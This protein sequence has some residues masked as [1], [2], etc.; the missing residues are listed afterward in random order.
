MKN[1]LILVFSIISMLIYTKNSK[2]GT[3]LEPYAGMALSSTYTI[4]GGGS[5]EISGTVVGGRL[6]FQQLGFMAGLD[7]RRQSYEFKP[8]SGSDS[9]VTF[10]QLGF[11]VGYDFPILL[12]V[13]GQY[14]F[15]Y[16]GED[17]DDADIKYTGGSGTVL[18]VGYKIFPFISVNLEYSNTSTSTYESSAGEVDRDI[19][20][21]SYLLSVSLPLSL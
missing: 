4:D 18:G 9:E 10:T 5:G 21:Q 12:R 2:A 7:G 11:F 6:G 20:Y 17:N 3:L 13:W 15:S 14:V 19:N 16:N 8:N 1:I